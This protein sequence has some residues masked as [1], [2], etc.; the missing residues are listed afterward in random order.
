MCLSCKYSYLL[1]KV[2]FSCEEKTKTEMKLAND[3]GAFFVMFSLVIQFPWMDMK[4][5]TTQV[6]PCWFFHSTDTCG[7]SP[8][9]QKR[10]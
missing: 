6:V 10:K 4:R 2:A 5:G 8:K 3:S 1:K 7:V 9:Q